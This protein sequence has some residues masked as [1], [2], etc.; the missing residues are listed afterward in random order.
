[1]PAERVPALR[2]ASS[3]SAGTSNG[4]YSQPKNSRAP[5][6]SAAPSGEP[7]ALLVPALVG[8][9]QPMVVLAAISVG[10][11][12]LCAFSIAAAMASRSR[13]SISMVFQP[14][15][16]KRAG[17]LLESASDTAPSIEMPL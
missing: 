7:C 4:G 13:P 14:Q 9:P 17:W 10:R 1:A 5:A 2:Q 8:A 16:A 6:M 12:E 15:A 3:T 11:S